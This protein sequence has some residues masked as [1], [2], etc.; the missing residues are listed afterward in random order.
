MG[1]SEDD[2]VAAIVREVIGDAARMAVLLE[3]WVMA[4]RMLANAVNE[5]KGDDTRAVVG[6]DRKWS[7]TM[8]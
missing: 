8:V 6:S 5:V 1:V 7:K 3:G 2:A 4:N